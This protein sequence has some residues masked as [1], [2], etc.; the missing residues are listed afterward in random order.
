M[1]PPRARFITGTVVRGDEIP[2]A[3]RPSVA[4][5]VAWV[6]VMVTLL[7]VTAAWSAVS[8][9]PRTVRRAV[10]ARPRTRGAH[11]AGRS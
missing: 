1:S 7:A 6:A 11:A 4:L 5:L 8:A 2:E 10:T 3:A 9:P